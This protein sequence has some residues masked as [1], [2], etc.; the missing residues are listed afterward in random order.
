[1]FRKYFAVIAL[2]AQVALAQDAKTVVDNAAKAM[3]VQN[4]GSVR[5]S[6][7]GLNFALGQAPNPSSPWPKFNG[8]NYSVS[9]VRGKSA[10]MLMHIK[11]RKEP[12]R[13]DLTCRGGNAAR[14]GEL[15]CWNIA[16]APLV[17]QPSFF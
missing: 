13:A 11:F 3:G 8:R 1:M 7:S 6:G 16:Q 4:L 9:V 15:S 5:Y 14:S 17:M 10:P 2:L 12:G